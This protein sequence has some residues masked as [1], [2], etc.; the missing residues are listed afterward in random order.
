MIQLIKLQ[1][2]SAANITIKHN[3]EIEMCNLFVVC[4]N[5]IHNYCVENVSIKC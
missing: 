4:L 3:Q 2:I 5:V 1:I